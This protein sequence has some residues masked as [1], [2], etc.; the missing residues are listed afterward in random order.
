MK[1]ADQRKAE[2]ADRLAKAAQEGTTDAIAGAIIDAID[3][4]LR[5]RNRP[6]RRDRADAD[7]RD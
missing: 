7:D 5:E 1:P 4:S 2:L 6:G 3:A